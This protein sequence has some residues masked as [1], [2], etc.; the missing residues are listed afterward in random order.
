LYKRRTKIE[1]AN[2]WMDSFKALLVRF[3]TNAKNWM[4]LQWMA[5]SIMFCKKIKV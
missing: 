1:H 2:A 3:E 5:L 4:A